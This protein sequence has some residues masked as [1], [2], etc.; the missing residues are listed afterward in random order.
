M[1]V[2]AC[3]KTRNFW[4]SQSFEFLFKEVYMYVG[5]Y[6]VDVLHV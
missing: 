5:E 4:V 6:E 2:Y 3:D 1:W